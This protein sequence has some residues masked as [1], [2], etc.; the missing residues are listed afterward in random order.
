MRPESVIKELDGAIRKAESLLD[1]MMAKSHGPA[2]TTEKRPLADKTPVVAEAPRKP[3]ELGDSLHNAYKEASDEAAL[4]V[5]EAQEQNNDGK[6][7]V[8]AKSKKGDVEITGRGK[9]VDGLVEGEAKAKFRL[10]EDVSVE[11]LLKTDSKKTAFGGSVLFNAGTNASVAT[12]AIFDTKGG[13]ALE[14]G[15][16]LKGDGFALDSAIGQSTKLGANASMDVLVSPMDNLE[17]GAGMKVSEREGIMGSGS[18]EYK[19]EPNVT[20]G[21]ELEVDAHGDVEGKVSLKI[22]F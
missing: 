10:T 3:E 21:G 1:T 13:Y 9:V 18:I 14:T 2:R 6:V 4:A 15:L 11:T 8:H 20:I 19:P 22:K 7:D 12:K 17:F 16:K 5:T